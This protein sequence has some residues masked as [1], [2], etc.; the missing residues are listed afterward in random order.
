MGLVGED[1]RLHPLVY[2]E[3]DKERD[4]MYFT[5]TMN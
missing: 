5:K 1:Q 4:N 3:I 2:Q